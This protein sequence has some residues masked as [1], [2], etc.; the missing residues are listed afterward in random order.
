M[1]KLVSLFLVT[2]LAAFGSQAVEKYVEGKHYTKVSDTASAKKEVREYFSF[3]CPH[4]LRFEPFMQDLARSLPEGVSFEKNHVDFLRAASEEVQFNITKALVVAEQLPQKNQL[5]GAI[6][7]EIQVQQRPITSEADIRKIFVMNGVDGEKF[8][9]MFKSFS[10]NSQ[11][12]KQ[13]KNQDDLV[14][15]RALTGVPTIV[16]NG[17]YRVN[18]NELDRSDFLND[19]KNLVIYLSQMN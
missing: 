9:K 15:K 11:A 10:V 8:D 2:A 1:K 19:Y 13:K 12:K 6:F 16:V 7:N 5:I 14:A 17:K 4:C 18:A 3:Y